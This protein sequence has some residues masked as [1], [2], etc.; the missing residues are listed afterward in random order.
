MTSKKVKDW[1]IINEPPAT[2]RHTEDSEFHSLEELMGK[3]FTTVHKDWRSLIVKEKETGKQKIIKKEDGEV[4]YLLRR[5][6]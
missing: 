3:E 6:I 1:K 4:V 5:K 2:F